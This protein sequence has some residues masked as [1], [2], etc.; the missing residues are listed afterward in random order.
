[1]IITRSPAESDATNLL[2]PFSDEDDT[3]IEVAPAFASDAKEVYSFTMV[4]A[5]V[6]VT[7]PSFPASALAVSDLKVPVMIKSRMQHTGM[8][9]AVIYIM[10]FWLSLWLLRDER[11]IG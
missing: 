6:I 8:A 2:L 11:R 9:A 10:F 4:F 1:M 3:E 7:G 5:V